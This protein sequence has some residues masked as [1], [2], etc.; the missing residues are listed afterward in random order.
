MTI[1]MFKALKTAEEKY[2]SRLKSMSKMDILELESLTHRSLNLNW[3][4]KFGFLP[5][6]KPIPYPECVDL[7]S[8]ETTLE[9]K[10]SGLITFKDELTSILLRAISSLA[11]RT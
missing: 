2:K 7:C 11:I 10:V 4:H 1:K 3:D 5:P 8:S 6:G 9:S